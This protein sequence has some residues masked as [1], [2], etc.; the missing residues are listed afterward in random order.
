MPPP[1]ERTAKSS[2]R[3][4]KSS[5]GPRLVSPQPA[6]I[7][8]GWVSAAHALLGLLRI[9]PYHVGGAAFVPGRRVFL[10]KDDV[11][12]E[13]RVVTAAPHGRGHLLIRLRGV[14][15]RDAAEALR[16]L[17]VYVAPEDLPPPDADEFYYHEVIGFRVETEDGMTIGE[18][19]ETMSTGLNDVWTVRDG[20]RE[21]LI[22]VID[23]VVRSI[24]RAIGR[25]II[26]PMPGLLD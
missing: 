20:K 17:M 8:V 2:S 5:S 6:A 14:E 12:Q 16:G 23:D 21:Y 26:S 10:E 15:D 7:A 11:W 19:V 22:P 18:V 13:A 25:I 9:R 4:S 1:P 24:D 3:S